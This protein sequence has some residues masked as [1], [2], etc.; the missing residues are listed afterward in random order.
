MANVMVKRRNGGGAG[1]K[2]F[3]Y[4]WCMA[5]SRQAHVMCGVMC[6]KFDARRVAVPCGVWRDKCD[7]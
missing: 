1:L 4:L 5:A 3:V 2:A 7:V 6:V